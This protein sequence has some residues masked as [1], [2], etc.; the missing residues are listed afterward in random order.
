[1]ASLKAQFQQ[2]TSMPTDPP[3]WTLV[4]IMVA[5]TVAGHKES[6]TCDEVRHPCL[7]ITGRQHRTGRR[8]LPAT[9]PSHPFYKRQLVSSIGPHRP[10]RCR[11]WDSPSRGPTPT[12]VSTAQPTSKSV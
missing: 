12:R 2:R 6:E 7:N 9:Y 11:P 10:I 3:F 8:R 5:T 1:Q 4:A